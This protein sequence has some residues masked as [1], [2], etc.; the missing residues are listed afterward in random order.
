M[1]GTQVRSPG[2]ARYQVSFKGDL[3]CINEQLL[4]MKE[5]CQTR[6]QSRREWLRGE[7]LASAFKCFAAGTA[8]SESLKSY[9]EAF[10]EETGTSAR[11]TARSYSVLRLDES[12]AGLALLYVFGFLQAVIF[13]WWRRMR[14]ARPLTKLPDREVD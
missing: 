3:H 7:L 14:R 9:F 12:V 11:A 13:A 6:D 10:N 8:R 5:V 1:E 4:Q 2:L